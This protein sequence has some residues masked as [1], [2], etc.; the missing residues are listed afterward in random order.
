VD[1]AI[2]VLRVYDAPSAA[3][4]YGR[5]G[6]E[7]E[8]EHRFGPT[9]PAFLSITRHG[10]ARLFLSEHHGD[11]PAG[12]LVYLQVAD[13]DAVAA[14]FGVEVLVQPWAREVHLTDPDGNRVRIGAPI[15]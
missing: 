5:L 13:V 1:Q 10:A 8:W 3:A 12:T 14:E 6:Y 4:W 2:P 15:P 11:A 9:F 7:K